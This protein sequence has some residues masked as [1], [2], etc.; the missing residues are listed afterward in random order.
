[1][2]IDTKDVTATGED[3]A[4][5]SY[6][7]SWAGEVAGTFNLSLTI[8]GSHIRGSP[9]PLTMLAAELDVSRC[10]CLAERSATAGAPEM[11]KLV[12]RDP[13]G[14]DA[15]TLLELRFGLV[16]LPVMSNESKSRSLSAAKGVPAND[17]A[18]GEKKSWNS[19][20]EERATLVK[21][22]PS[23]AF[24]GSWEGA[25]YSLAYVPQEAGDFELHVWVDKDGDGTRTFFPGCPFAL[26][27]APGKASASASAVREAGAL[28]E[29]GLG[30]GER[31]SFKV[32]LHDVYGNCAPLTSPSD[33][34]HATLALPPH[35]EIVS[36]SLKQA[37][38]DEH[39][40]TRQS[41]K[42]N[43]TA[44]STV[45]VGLAHGSSHRAVP[46]PCPTRHPCPLLP[47]L[48]GSYAPARLRA[49][50]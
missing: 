35:G 44:S 30:A 26:H 25:T 41:S 21:T 49:S 16:L 6:L 39:T 9:T 18:V 27:V 32:Q 34:L 3:Q 48:P 2:S 17:G 37:V 33:E 24:E 10:E 20:R 15:G 31:L 12:C 19:I 43:I 38:V 11:I 4:D 47:L 40:L 28:S 22:M 23:F 7:I 42:K 13:F 46:F 50:L 29:G 8:D 36:L 45:A 1:M 5:G 14:N